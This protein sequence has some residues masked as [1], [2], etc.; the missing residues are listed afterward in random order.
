MP[1][2]PRS[3]NKTNLVIGRIEVMKTTTVPFFVVSMLWLVPAIP[4]SADQI[5]FNFRSKAQ[6][7]ADLETKQR[8]VQTIAADE[9][10]SP[11]AKKVRIRCHGGHVTISGHAHSPEEKE[12]LTTITKGV[13]GVKSVRNG[14]TIR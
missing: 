4:A 1:T 9:T 12:Y 13:P 10:L 11:K 6:D 7:Q 14:V 8:V 2:V 3:T 5:N